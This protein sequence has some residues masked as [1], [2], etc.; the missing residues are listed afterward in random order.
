MSDLKQDIAQ[1]K[2]AGVKMAEASTQEKHTAL[3]HIAALLEEQTDFIIQENKLDLD[4]LA[5]KEGYSKAFYDRLQLTPDRIKGM[6]EGLREII[7]LPDPVGEIISM[8]KRPNGLQVGRVRVPL[9]VIGIIYEARPNVTVDAAGLAL[10]SGNSVVLRGSSE[11]IHSNKALARLLKQGLQENNLPQGAVTLVE[12]TGRAAALELMKMNEFLDVLIPRGGAALIKTVVENATVPVL[13]TGEGNC[14]T[15]VDADTDEEMAVEIAD[16]AKTQR[17]G[18]CNAMETLLVHQD[19]ASRYLP[20]ILKLLQEKG[21]Q[22]RGCRKTLDIFPGIQQATDEDWATEYLDMVLAVK[23][24]DSF[25]E[26]VAHIN[27]YGTGHSEAILTSSY[28]RAH[29]FLARVDAAAVYVNASTR[30]TDGFEFGLGA[31]MGISTQKL[32]A[33]G[34][35]GLTALTSTKFIIL[36]QGQA[37]N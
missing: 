7:A 2:E 1:A 3:E 28:Q 25:D 19:I 15:Y 9:G 17:P 30:F 36:G 23:I 21:V 31:E 12:D 4:N 29:T 16:N 24:V 22:L 34:P 14:H 32:H 10:K 35:M 37:R 5:A 8:W 20:K 33:R 13:E 27:Q 11:A 6:A 18:V 26:A